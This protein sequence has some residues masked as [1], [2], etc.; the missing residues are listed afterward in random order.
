M[1]RVKDPT[2]FKGRDCRGVMIGPSNFE[3]KQGGLVTWTAPHISRI[4]SSGRKEERSWHELLVGMFPIGNLPLGLQDIRNRLRQV[5]TAFAIQ[6]HKGNI[7]KVVGSSFCDDGQECRV[8]ACSLQETT[9]LDLAK[10]AK[11]NELNRR[12]ELSEESKE[13]VARVRRGQGQAQIAR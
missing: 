5:D 9:F 2:A 12:L 13:V 4:G 6:S 3:D 1:C 8:I 10:K 11:F 7:L